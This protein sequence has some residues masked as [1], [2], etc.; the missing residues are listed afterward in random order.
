MFHKHIRLIY[1]TDRVRVLYLKMDFLVTFVK[2][3]IGSG[4]VKTIEHKEPD[5]HFLICQ[6]FLDSPNMSTENNEPYQ[7]IVFKILTW[8]FLLFWR[9]VIR[10]YKLKK[11]WL[12][13]KHPLRWI[14]IEIKSGSDLFL[15]N[16]I[17]YYYICKTKKVPYNFFKIT[18]FLQCQNIVCW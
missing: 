1:W 3:N 16:L 17:I 11:F 18:V 14:I 6:G 12:S 7:N 9:N 10:I 13:P 15:L 8:F 4:P 5:N 2:P